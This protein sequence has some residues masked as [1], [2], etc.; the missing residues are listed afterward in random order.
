MRK[1]AQHGA[2]VIAFE[3]AVNRASRFGVDGDDIWLPEKLEKQIALV[4][5]KPEAS[6][7]FTN[8]M[9]FDESGDVRPFYSD[10]E[11]FCS[12]DLLEHSLG[13]CRFYTS[14]TMVRRRDLVEAGLF[15]TDLDR[16]S[17]Y[18]MWLRLLMSGKV[19][20]GVWEHLTKYRVH[21]ASISDNRTRVNAA[22]LEVY[23]SALARARDSHH[24]GIIR[25]S[26]MRTASCTHLAAAPQMLRDGDCSTR[27]LRM[28]LWRAW[29]VYPR[30]VRPLR[31]LLMD[32][33]G[34]RGRVAKHLAR[35]W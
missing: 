6:I 12:H 8:G 29:C 28:D 5:E 22:M 31:Y 26:M 17:D 23:S 35:R 24:Q 18:D 10:P 15:R 32:V 21:T 30:S 19:A 11:E 33:L 13:C 25:D 27:R 1:H 16:V 2:D 34:M 9:E 4:Q 7:V 14:S 3:L 20:E